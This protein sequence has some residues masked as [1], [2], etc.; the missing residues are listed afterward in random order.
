MAD[1]YKFVIEGTD[2]T[3]EMFKSLKANLGNLRGALNSTAT[4]VAGLAG[5]AG[6]GALVS[7]S[8]KANDALAKTADRL[9]LTTQSL[10]G[11]QHAA[12]LSG[13]GTDTLN[14]ALQRMT[15]RVAEAAQ[16]TGEAKGALQEL[17]I[18]A[19]KLA[20]MSPD[21]QFRAI[22]GAMEGVAGQGDKVRLAM[23]LFDSEGVKLV[24]TLAMGE[25]GLNEAQREA[26]AY[27][28]ALSRVDAAKM[29]AANDAIFRAQQVGK[30][31]TNQL[32]IQL[33]PIIEEIANQFA[34]A[35]QA[36]GGM[37]AMV[38]GAFKKGVSVVGVFADG[39]HG[40]KIIFQGLVTLGQALF[41]GW[42][43]GFTKV[44]EVIGSVANGIVD[45]IVWPI[46]KVL[47]LLAPFNDGAA[48]ALASVD[49][50]VEKIRISAPEGL[51]A[52]AA[53]Q[54]E[55]FEE[56][57]EKLNELLL[58]ELPSDVLKSKVEEI[59]AAA[60]VRAQEIAAAAQGGAGLPTKAA[61]DE[62]AEKGADGLSESER[63][64][65]AARLETLKLSWLSEQEQLAVKH[66]EEMAILDAAFAE[67]L[68]KQD[69]YERSLTELEKKHQKEREAIQQVAGKSNLEL[70]TDGAKQLLSAA[71]AQN[72]KMA[73]LQM[74]MAVFT[75]G[76]AMV[77]NIAE[78]SKIGFPQNIPMII[79]ATTQGMQ[80]AAQLN[81]IKQPSGIAHGG[82]DY[83]PAESTYLLDKG[84]RVLSPNQNADLT[85][86]LKNGGLGSNVQVHIHQDGVGG[87]H[88]EQSKGI[89]G[90]DV[91][92]IVVANIGQGGEI[93]SEME[94]RYNLQRQGRY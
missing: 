30:G 87:G 85:S 79:G 22:A 39:I 31:L 35:A 62:G 5:A 78:A 13:A 23:K 88:V 83:V 77:Q 18:D 15:R 65:L 49:A 84:E 2:K 7:S 81:S 67:K 93:G 69:E 86:A 59:L 20:A 44:I 32:T 17:G 34:A 11:L 63:N 51:K 66:D 72:K 41:A 70:F 19:Q 58:T 29:E 16:G 10:A 43:T 54:R 21:Q 80:I 14:M 60:Q 42:I 57:R 89:N 12:E 92:R 33:A 6:L 71:G 40:I 64:Q 36:G 27:G 45:G 38:E 76:T 48:N 94:S 90:E 46:R 47:E 61:N 68:I 37:G 91:I 4:K 25:Q 74:G 28:V 73:A 3:R 56:S 53:A 50:L 9:G 1:N 24:N 55:A 75:A 82:L 52:F 26:E 8:L